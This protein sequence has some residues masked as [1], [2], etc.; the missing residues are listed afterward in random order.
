MAE[1]KDALNVR[2]LVG[3]ILLTIFAIGTLGYSQSL[4][5]IAWLGVIRQ[6][7][8]FLYFYSAWSIGLAIWY[9]VTLKKQPN[10]K[11][12]L[13]VKIIFFVVI[14][15]N[16]IYAAML[17]YSNATC[18]GVVLMI[19]YS[20]GCPWGKKGY[21]HNPYSEILENKTLDSNNNNTQSWYKTWWVW[22]VIILAILI[23]SIGFFLLT[24]GSVRNGA[25]TTSPLT[26]KQKTDK[27]SIE[28]D[29]KK[30]K[31]SA[32]KT[33][34]VNYTND[35]WQGADIKISKIVIY[36]TIKPY[37]FHSSN[38]GNFK[39]NGFARVYMS[40]KS[41]EDISAYPTQGTFS[42]SN[43]EQHGVDST[44]NWD[45]DIN[46]G[47][48]KSGTITVPI[49]KINSTSSLKSIRM[50]FDA[51]EQDADDDSGYKTYDLTIDLK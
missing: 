37:K 15:L 23:F 33:Y 17:D 27:N 26:T 31:I 3:A 36:K 16:A 29:Y 20:I 51:S 44:E 5:G 45:G 39:L 21:K 34:K 32:L 40:I 13:I 28:V 41:K 49:E 50:K 7:Q 10:K 25:N 2:R 30:Y 14:A 8:Q 12:E 1:N 18:L 9:F 42:Y 4:M 48:V 46:E 43:G 11:A 19:C 6:Y 35:E 22:L 38:D 24:D 47:V